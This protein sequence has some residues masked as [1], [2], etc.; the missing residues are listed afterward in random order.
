M[1]FCLPSCAATS[2]VVLFLAASSSSGL[3]A[4]TAWQE[5]SS[6][7]ISL[8]AGGATLFTKEFRGPEPGKVSYIV[9]SES[10][11]ELRVIAQASDKDSA[12]SVSDLLKSS[13]AVGGVNGGYF[14]APLLIPS[15]LEI[16]SGKSEGAAW[17]GDPHIGS[18]IVR[19]GIISLEW[20]AEWKGT[21]NVSELLQCSP[22]LVSGGLPPKDFSPDK[23]QRLRRSFIAT[24]GKKQWALGICEKMT[25]AGLAAML[26]SQQ[27]VRE[28]KIE[29]ALNLDGGPSSGLWAAQSDGKEYYYREFWRV[30]NVLGVFAK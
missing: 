12:K 17:R 16:S 15:G 10:S 27:V 9:F 8:K 21:E 14:K 24:D 30:R 3:S 18:C 20:D 19:K 11:C 23:D 7:G 22:W 5:V 28:L 13:G 2:L 26:A 29:R 4:D 25:L 6:P 1:T